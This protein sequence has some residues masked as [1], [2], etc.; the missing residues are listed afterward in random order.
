MKIAVIGAGSMGSLYGGFLSKKHDVYL[1][2]VWQEHVDKINSDGL[3]LEELDGTQNKFFPKAV[4]STEGVPEV[5]LVIVFVKSIQTAES[6]KN[7]SSIIGK[8][9]ILMSL[10]NGYGND[11]DMVEYADVDRIVMGTTSHGCYVIGPGHVKHAG[12]GDTIIG[13]YSDNQ[14]AAE[15]LKDVFEEVGFVTLV[16][17]N[18]KTLV[19][20]KLFVNIGINPLTALLDVK[21]SR[22]ADNEFL[23]EVAKSLV[24]EAVDVAVKSGLEFDA[25]EEFD[26]VC[27]VAHLT[28]ENISSMRA[29]VQRKRPTEIGKINGAIVTMA[30]DLGIEAPANKLIVDL[31]RAKELEY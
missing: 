5:D 2:D 10:Q 30:E 7:H 19:L 27:E 11:R 31:I 17:E 8:N 25:E 23:R 28:G 4:T 14:E 16:N 9:T 13:T 18:V 29:D 15:K 21:N 3:I 1:I 24:Y 22:M 20:K 26:H 12:V 6:L